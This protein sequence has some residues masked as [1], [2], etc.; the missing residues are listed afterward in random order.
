MGKH[1]LDRGGEI[2]FRYISSDSQLTRMYCNGASGKDL[3][4]QES[5]EPLREN[6][7]IDGK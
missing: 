4:D 2:C 3:Q 5:R 1:R 6:S 7:R